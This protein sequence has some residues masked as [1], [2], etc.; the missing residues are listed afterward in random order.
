MR[1]P[2]S[3]LQTKTCSSRYSRTRD[4]VSQGDPN[5]GL[6]RYASLRRNL[7]SFFL[8]SRVILSGN[9]YIQRNNGTGLR[10]GWREGVDK[11]VKK[12]LMADKHLVSESQMQ[13]YNDT[14]HPTI[15][16]IL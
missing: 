9:S 2:T 6:S 16:I 8:P 5:N 4:S 14:P 1:G 15:W 11:S 3:Y 12:F 10:E 13:Q 7:F